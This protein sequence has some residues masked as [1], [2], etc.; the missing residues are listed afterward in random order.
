MR[1]ISIAVGACAALLLVAGCKNAYG[2]SQS[3]SNQNKANDQANVNTNTDAEQLALDAAQPFILT[4]Q[5]NSGETGTAKIFDVNGKAEVV[6]NMSGAPDG[7]SQPAHIHEGTCA[8][9]GP[10][11]F[12]LTNVLDGASK[13]NLNVPMSAIFNGSP[14]ALN[15]H[16]SQAES[17]VYV[18]CVDLTGK[19]NEG[20]NTN[21]SV[22]ANSNANTNTNTSETSQKKTF[23][24][25]A[26]NFSFSLKEI[27][28][29]KGDTVTI[30]L[31][32]SDGFHD[33]VLDEFNART[34]QIGV[35]SSD[36]VTFV[37]DNTGTFEY[38]CS[39]GQHR[40]AGMKG[41]LIVE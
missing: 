35:G 17:G 7:V 8:K 6:L 2:P 22:N 25:T 39:V 10:V 38:Y 14:R 31:S 24:I 15:V 19:V 4:A 18:A 26:R 11:V 12:G 13:T 27:R 33:W 16:K 20:Q 36:S 32:N 21:S 9:L 30:N 28:V 3:R 29:K 1:R 34:K 41:N 37:V 23:N 5:N 40:A